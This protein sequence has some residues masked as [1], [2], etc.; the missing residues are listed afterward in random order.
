M[1]AACVPMKP[2]ALAKSR[3]APYLSGE[4]RAS[5]ARLLLDR[6]ITA[7]E[8]SGVVDFSAVATREPAIVDELRVTVLPDRGDLNSSL[9]GAIEW[10][11]ET[12]AERLL[13]LPGD[14]PLLRPGDI[15][16]LVNLSHSPPDV[17][18]VQTQEGGTGALL[19]TPPNVIAADFGGRSFERHLALARRA[20]ARTHSTEI[21]GLSF[22]LDTPDDLQ[23][24][25]AY[26][27]PYGESL[28]PMRRR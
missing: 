8:D 3:L 18:I 17:V 9:A 13:L 1:I 23:A 26:L 27:P 15:R 5:L 14:L 10:A 28:P 25:A 20:G 22:D 19:L 7:L 16:T 2:L 4:Q 24:V 12:G 11:C 6:T 21:R